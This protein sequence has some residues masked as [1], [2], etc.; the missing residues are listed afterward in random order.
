[1]RLSNR[2]FT[3]GP[4]AVTAKVEDRNQNKHQ[5]QSQPVID[6]CGLHAGHDQHIQAQTDERDGNEAQQN[7]AMERGGKC[8]KRIQQPACKCA[9]HKASD[10]GGDMTEDAQLGKSHGASGVARA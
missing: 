3:V 2:S 1:M 6:A 4:Q 9:E 7:S 10:L 8:P 5:K